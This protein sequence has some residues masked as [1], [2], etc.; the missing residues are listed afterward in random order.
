MDLIDSADGWCERNQGSV[1]LLCRMA[2]L[3]AVARGPILLRLPFS[4]TLYLISTG[5]VRYDN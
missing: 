1:N 2:V 5:G 3:S 4:D